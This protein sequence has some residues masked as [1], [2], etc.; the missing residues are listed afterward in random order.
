MLS[1]TMTLMLLMSQMLGLAGERA[2]VA[3]IVS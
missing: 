1:L 3:V 2:R